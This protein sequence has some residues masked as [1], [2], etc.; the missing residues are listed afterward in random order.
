[1][2]LPGLEMIIPLLSQYLWSYKRPVSNPVDLVRQFLSKPPI[3]FTVIGE[4]T[5]FM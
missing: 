5:N 4:F 3:P 1:M 2:L